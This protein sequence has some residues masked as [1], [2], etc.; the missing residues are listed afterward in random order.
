[1]CHLSQLHRNLG[2]V[3]IEVSN[4]KVTLAAVSRLMRKECRQ[5]MYSEIGGKK[6]DETFVAMVE[7]C[8]MLHISK[9]IKKHNFE[10][11]FHLG[12]HTVISGGFDFEG[13]DVFMHRTTPHLLNNMTCAV[14]CGW[15]TQAHFDGAFN[16]CTKDFGVIGMGMNSM[17][18]K[19]NTVLLSLAGIWLT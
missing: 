8:K 19:L 14:E 18:T 3:G 5:I 11:D 10:S 7:V 6:M 13:S 16:L 17:G 15:P 1:V 12:M 4:D 2:N 9:L